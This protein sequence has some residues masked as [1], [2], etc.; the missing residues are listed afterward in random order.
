MTDEQLLTI[1][2]ILNAD[3]MH[4]YY[5]D[6]NNKN[7]KRVCYTIR[8]RDNSD[9]YTITFL[10][11]DKRIELTMYDIK[12]LS[13]EQYHKIVKCCDLLDWK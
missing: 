10:I 4:Y 9:Y 13:A 3:E 2:K 8:E 11:N 5:H 6:Y 7:E 12:S 1:K